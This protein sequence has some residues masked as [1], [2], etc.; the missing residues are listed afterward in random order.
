MSWKTDPYW[1]K[2]QAEFDAY[3]KSFEAANENIVKG[4]KKVKSTKKT[5]KKK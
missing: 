5:S 1:P 4:E 3:K 2:T